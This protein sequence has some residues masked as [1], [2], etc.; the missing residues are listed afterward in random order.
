MEL[1][2]KLHLNWEVVVLV[3]E[4]VVVLP[5]FLLGKMGRKCEKKVN[6]ICFVK[7]NLLID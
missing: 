4:V 6:R 2:P 3:E 5:Y 1:L 7:Y